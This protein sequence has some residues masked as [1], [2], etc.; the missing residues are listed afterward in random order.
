M[1]EILLF[2][3]SDVCIPDADGSGQV[4]IELIFHGF[5]IAIGKSSTECVQICTL[6]PVLQNVFYQ[7]CLIYIVKPAF[8]DFLEIF[9]ADR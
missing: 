7:T 9:N 1:V 8:A 4:G 5:D 6:A 2:I 3:F